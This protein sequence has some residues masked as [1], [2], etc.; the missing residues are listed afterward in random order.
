MGSNNFSIMY[1]S[2]MDEYNVDCKPLIR[3]SE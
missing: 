3:T 2:S 1:R